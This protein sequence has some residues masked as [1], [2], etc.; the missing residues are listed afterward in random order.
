[1]TLNFAAVDLGAESGRVMLG[2]LEGGRLALEEAHRFPNTPVQAGGT[3]YWDILRVWSEIKHGLAVCGRQAGGPVAS[4][5]VCTWGVD[6][7]LVGRDGALLGNP[8]HYRDV[9]TQGQIEAATARV[10]RAEIF[11]QTG[12]QFIAINTLYQLLALQAQG[13]PALEAAHRL[14]TIPDLLNYWLSGAAVN[15]FTNATTT[16]CLNP[17]TGDWAWDLL[18][19]LGL[20]RRIFGPIVQPGTALGPLSAAISAELSLPAVPVIAPA[21]HDTGSAVAAAP[22][23]GDGSIYISSGTWSLMGV[24]LPRP[25]ITERSLA[26]NFT[27]EGGVNGTFRLLKNIMGLWIVQECRRTW[28]S[29]GEDYGYAQLTALAEQAAPLVSLIDAA[30]ERFFAPGDMPARIRAACQSTGQPVPESAGAIVRCALESLA[31]EY[32]FVA[33]R[34]DELTGR[35]L[36]FIHIIGGGAQNALLNAFTANATGRRVVAG[37]VEATALGNVLVQAIAGGHLASLAEG[38]DLVRR[39]FPVVT[40]EPQTT[41]AWETAY[42]RYLQ[43]KPGLP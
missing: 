34:L 38:R 4:I 18:D 6:F 17:A 22:L 15:E 36:P 32:R 31:L 1:M 29:L 5:G 42:Q 40:I 30:D 16:Q 23:T 8:V 9:R 25:V 3:L 35:R 14:L 11:A 21:T 33:E 43:L 19:R 10:P 12:I 37:P 28:A 13:S 20:P 26:Y 7:A 41:P 24:E 39:S 2:R 27:N